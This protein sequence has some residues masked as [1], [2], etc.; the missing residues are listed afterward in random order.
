MARK[1][2]APKLQINYMSGAE[3]KAWA[4]GVPV[5]CAHD[6]IEQTASL[7]PNPK[8]PNKHPES[9]VELLAQIIQAQGWRNPI[10][11][12]NLSGMVV[13]GH[14]RLLAAKLLGRTEVPV[15]HQNYA[16]EAEEYADL[17]AD[18]RLS[19]LSEIDN[20]AIAD[21]LADLDTGDVPIEL[22]GYTEDDLE[23]LIAAISGTDDTE[24]DQVDETPEPPV[25]T[26]SKR[27]DLWHVGDHRI[28]CGDSTDPA[29]I[30]RLMQGDLAQVVNTDPPYGVVYTGGHDKEWDA[31][32]NDALEHDDLMTK[33]LIPALRN[34]VRNAR[35]DAAF[36]IWH[37]SSTRR[38]FED[39]MTAVGLLEKQYLIWVKNNIQMG[40]S[41]YQWAHEPCYY[42]EKAGQSAKWCGDRKQST[43]WKVTLRD[44]DGLATTLTGGLVVTDG[45]GRKI[46]IA[47]KPPKGKKIRY[48][49]LSDGRSVT[50]YT[51]QQTN[52]VWEVAKETGYKHPT[53]KPV[54]LAVRAIENSSEI[55]DIVL[56]V[57]GGSHSTMI[58]AEL[59][60]RK[61][62]I[63][64]LE[65]KYVDVGLL[66]YVKLK[67]LNNTITC[68]RDGQVYG[69]L[70]LCQ[71]ICDENGISIQGLI[72]GTY[73]TEEG[74]D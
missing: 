70:E 43:A 65:P 13:K 72:D 53:Q 5:F 35:N 71:H 2:K 37:A 9:Q 64:E 40:R 62:R 58:G 10:T 54:E 31:I 4:D 32:A 3:P 49:R 8:N 6:A 33:L 63:C 7:V 20:V 60:G 11:I 39:A 73:T 1:K 27:G 50:I 67:G 28:I 23:S 22:T 74:G 47:D 30:D 61:A 56:D 66:R 29:T 48:L 44:N 52:T 55:G 12:S 38:D 42:A 21:L 17:I 34:C 18:N 15:D 36:Y 24:D 59:T 19:E 26:I 14:G 45:A 25:L 68:E 57:F 46:Y 51:E 16:S 69:F 41:D